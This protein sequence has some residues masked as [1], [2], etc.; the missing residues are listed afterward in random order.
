MLALVWDLQLY[1]TCTTGTIIREAERE[2]RIETWFV[3]SAKLLLNR[4]DYKKMYLFQALHS[5]EHNYNHF[6]DCSCKAHF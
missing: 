2:T 3:I 1:V 4:S 5:T 6:L